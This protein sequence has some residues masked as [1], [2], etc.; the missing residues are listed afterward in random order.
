MIQTPFVLASL[1]VLKSSFM[2]TMVWCGDSQLEHTQVLQLAW[3]YHKIVPLEVD[4]N[5]ACTGSSIDCKTNTGVV[6]ESP[7]RPQ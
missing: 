1:L 5:A 7:K 6:C 3:A 4:A 2:V